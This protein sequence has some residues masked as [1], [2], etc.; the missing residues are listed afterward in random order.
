MNARN[1]Y[2][3]ILMACLLA[4]SLAGLGPAAN[5]ASAGKLSF[6]PG[7]SLPGHAIEIIG[8][9]RYDRRRAPQ[10]YPPITPRYPLYDY[11]YYYSRGYY[12]E[13]IRGHINFLY[14]YRCDYYFREYSSPYCR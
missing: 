10:V 4:M 14:G 2:V 3:A 13:H 7:A 11:P 5:A 8:R 6:N 9:R 1:V 12:P